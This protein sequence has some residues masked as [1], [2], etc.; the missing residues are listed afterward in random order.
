M[1]F[2]IFGKT[3][4]WWNCIHKSI[5]MNRQAHTWIFAIVFSVTT[6]STAL[7]ADWRVAKIF[8][9]AWVGTSGVQ[10][11]SLSRGAPL[12]D[13]ATVRTGRDGKVVLVRG[14]GSM[15]VS[16]NSIVTLPAEETAGWTVIEQQAGIVT[17]DVEKR[18]VLH[19]EVRTPTIVA[20]VKGTQFKVT[21]NQYGSKV[22]VTE[23]LVQVGQR[24]T[25]ESA[26]V[27]PGQ[28]AVLDNRPRGR[29]R[30]VGPGIKDK[31][32]KKAEI[33][34]ATAAAG[35]AAG[36]GNSGNGNS[37]NGNS[38]NGNSG[39]GNSGNGNSGNGNSGNGNGNSGDANNGNGRG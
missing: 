35:A 7:A 23:G 27:K 4:S 16:A 30:V 24:S 28:K 2:K 13:N 25:G 3:S 33:D 20:V 34:A 11:V 18:N 1:F 37:R 29:L 38:G 21:Q 39:N 14:Q 17:Y 26:F 15:I 12:E 36:K 10:N 9:D 22:T 6:A 5:K 31:P 32:M 8:G 19:F